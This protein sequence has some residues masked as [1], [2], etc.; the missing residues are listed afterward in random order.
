MQHHRKKLRLSHTDYSSDGVYFITTCCKNRIQHFGLIQNGKM[1]LNQSGEIAQQ[2]FSWLENQ[3][4]YLIIHNVVI[5]PDHIHVLLEIDRS[6]GINGCKIKSVS[7]LMGAYKTTSSKLIH[8]SGNMDFEWQRSFHDHIVRN[9]QSYENIY[10][11]ITDNPIKW[12]KKP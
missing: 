6:K 2:Q 7:S 9:Q 5:M 1:Q 12:G 11:Y 8:L 4:S 3:Y 10:Q